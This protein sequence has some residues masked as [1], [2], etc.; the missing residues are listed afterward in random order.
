MATKSKWNACWSLTST[1]QKRWTRPMCLRGSQPSGRNVAASLTL[2][3]MNKMLL[4]F[5]SRVT[6]L[7]WI[8][9]IHLVKTSDAG[10]EGCLYQLHS[11]EYSDTV[12]F[13]NMSV[14]HILKFRIMAEIVRICF[15]F[16]F[17]EAT[18]KTSNINTK[19][20]KEHLS[21]EASWHRDSSSYFLVWLLLSDHHA[22]VHQGP[23]HAKILLLEAKTPSQATFP[24]F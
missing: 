23:G 3:S 14:I 20:T 9:K 18:E 19:V 4:M 7:F 13:S 21:W 22:A 2:P 24:L 8:R 10:N 15:F 12:E 1:S 16:F 5:T 6:I 11:K 17:G